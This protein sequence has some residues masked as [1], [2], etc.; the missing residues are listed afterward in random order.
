MRTDSTN[1][2]NTQISNR[3]TQIESPGIP[4][5]YLLDAQ[6]I[7]ALALR[8]LSEKI[9]TLKSNG[10][11]KALDLSLPQSIENTIKP[12]G[13]ILGKLDNLHKLTIQAEQIAKT[14]SMNIKGKVVD[15]TY[16]ME[17][18]AFA[19][20][21]LS[22]KEV[23]KEIQ[24]LPKDFPVKEKYELLES[25]YSRTWD[26]NPEIAMEALKELPK[27]HPGMKEMQEKAQKRLDKPGHY[28]CHKWG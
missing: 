1:N 14:K 6:K 20:L 5:S 2:K 18:T 15:V 12:Y 27:D 21:K 7:K 26:H 22:S 13:K 10:T 3:N 23:L 19:Q 28:S 24:N 4:C 11:I 8:I 9:T 25:L 16:K 17:Q